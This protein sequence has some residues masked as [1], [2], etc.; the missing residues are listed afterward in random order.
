MSSGRQMFGA[1]QT[2]YMDANGNPVVVP[3]QY[4]QSCPG[5]CPSYSG[6]MEYGPPC[7]GGPYGGAPCDGGSYGPPHYGG[8]TGP[9]PMG[10]GGTDPAVGYDLMEDVGMEGFLVDQRGPHYFDVAPRGRVAD[11]R[12]DVR[13]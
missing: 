4:A 7:D 2:P 10:A 8:F 13:S 5:G 1:K 12:R 9:M 11:R 6:P 3:A